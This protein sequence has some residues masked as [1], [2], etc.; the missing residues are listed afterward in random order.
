MIAVA[1]VFGWLAVAGSV[2]EDELE[3]ALERGRSLHSEQRWADAEVQWGRVLELESVNAEAWHKLGY[4]QH[5]MAKWRP[6]SIAHQRATQVATE[7]DAEIR[8]RAYYDLACCWVQ[9]GQR[10]DA[11]HALES[12]VKAGLNN[13]EYM[14]ADPHLEALSEEPGFERI[15]ADLRRGRRNVAILV[16]AGAKLFDFA[17]PAEVFSTAHIPGKGRQFNVFT[18]GEYAQPLVCGSVRITPEYSFDT[19]PR[20]DVVVIPGGQTAIAQGSV[21]A[22][23]WI[24]ESAAN[25]EA[26]I[27]V[28]S[29][30]LLLV[31]TRV[32]K[33]E[34]V[35]TSPEAEESLEREASAL[36]IVQD[37]SF[38]DAGS[39]VSARDGFAAVD[40][41]LHVVL[42]LL[43]RDARD[44]TA[45]RFG[46]VVDPEGSKKARR[47]NF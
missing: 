14:L 28:G 39:V 40:A 21:E 36:Q 27:S 19:C 17:G 5:R 33:G 45:R 29:G 30:V 38:V 20:P 37:R 3:L 24:K 1:A 15:I 43:G 13:P 31:D 2:A 12:A 16:H 11:I 10:A 34:R 25:A 44:A 23:R 35:V 22:L 4:A 7:D 41:S 47:Q 32:L 6:A 18:V 42:E 46:R 9:L 26:I 8:L